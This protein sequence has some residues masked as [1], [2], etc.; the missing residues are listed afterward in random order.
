M[1]FDKVPAP[2]R[3]KP[4]IDIHA[5][6]RRA[7]AEMGEVE[8]GT[9]GQGRSVTLL[10]LLEAEC[11]SPQYARAA[12]ALIAA[13]YDREMVVEWERL[14]RPMAVGSPSAA[15]LAD[16]KNLWREARR[17][18]WRIVADFAQ[19]IAGIVFLVTLVVLLARGFVLDP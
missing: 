15:A 6:R 11:P 12:M 19:V 14:F 8:I 16:E 18:R 1:V 3:P 13:A 7:R 17:L 2:D 9:D 4:A 10:R 5:A